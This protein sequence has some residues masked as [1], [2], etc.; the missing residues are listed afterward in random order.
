[1][2]EFYNFGRQLRDV[3][4]GLLLS[5]EDGPRKPSPRLE[6]ISRDTAT[7]ETLLAYLSVQRRT[8]VVRR[9]AEAEVKMALHAVDVGPS[10]WRVKTEMHGREF[11]DDFTLATTD[12][13]PPEDEVPKPGNKK[14]LDNCECGDKHDGKDYGC[15]NYPVSENSIHAISETFKRC[16]SKNGSKCTH[17]WKEVGHTTHWDKMQCKGKIFIIEYEYQWRCD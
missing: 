4:R 14:V 7:Q 5:T 15:H 6:M 16:E 17:T 12:E 9:G 2:S 11:E 13:D 3:L 1:V 10:T 8:I